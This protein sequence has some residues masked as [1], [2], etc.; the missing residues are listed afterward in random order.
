MDEETEKKIIRRP[1]LGILSILLLFILY[2]VFTVYTV[3]SGDCRPKPVDPNQRLA[4]FDEHGR[5]VTFPERINYP[6]QTRPLIDYYGKWA[7]SGD[8]KAP[9]YRKIRGTGPVEEVTARA[10]AALT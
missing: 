3:R 9:K 5:L 4:T 6:A 1:I 2:R 7:A 10:L 8:K